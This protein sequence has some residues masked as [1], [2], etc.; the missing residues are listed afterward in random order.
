MVR[1]RKI[2]TALRTNQIAEFVTVTA[3]KKIIVNNIQVTISVT[4]QC[5]SWQMEATSSA[6][7]I[8]WKFDMWI[9]AWKLI[10]SLQIM[11]ENWAVSFC[12]E[13]QSV[14]TVEL[15]NLTTKQRKTSLWLWC[16]F[17][18]KCFSSGCGTVCKL[19]VQVKLSALTK[20]PRNE[21]KIY[22]ETEFHSSEGH[23][24]NF[25]WL[26]PDLSF[27]NGLLYRL[28]LPLEVLTAFW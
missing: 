6:N 16:G 22:Q 23:L 18:A 15:K 28:D 3:W 8:G 11:Y 25:S 20:I 2:R 24:F 13:K 5:F 27:F 1:D 9:Q 4:L 10:H 12:R 19:V 7:F 17:L 21:A 26:L 14:L